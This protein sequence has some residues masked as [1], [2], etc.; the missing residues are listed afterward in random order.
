MGWYNSLNWAT[1]FFPMEF[2]FVYCSLARKKT[3]GSILLHLSNFFAACQIQVPA[4]AKRPTLIPLKQYVNRSTG[5][6]NAVPTGNDR[7]EVP[8]CICMHLLGGVLPAGKDRTRLPEFHRGLCAKKC[9]RVGM[10]Q[11]PRSVAGEFP[12]KIYGNIFFGQSWKNK[13]FWASDLRKDHFYK[14]SAGSYACEKPVMHGL[15]LQNLWSL[16]VRCSIC[17]TIHLSIQ[18]IWSFDAEKNPM[19]IGRRPFCGWWK[20]MIFLCPKFWWTLG[21]TKPARKKS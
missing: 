18:P 17:T 7:F 4:T 20:S 13:G 3:R 11:T 15:H 6:W 10:C 1:C 8:C 2:R 9:W 21:S 14:L 19:F 16:A 5:F 12:Q